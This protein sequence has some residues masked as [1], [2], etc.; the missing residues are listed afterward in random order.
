[1]QINRYCLTSIQSQSFKRLVSECLIYT[2]Q[3][4]ETCENCQSEENKTLH[5]IT[6]RCLLQNQNLNESQEE[7]VSSC[8]GMIKCAHSEIKL[9]WGPPGTGK[10]KTLACLL[11]CLHKL[12]HRSLACAPTNTAIL[13]VAARLH[14]LFQGSAEY[15]TYG[16][17][18]IVLMGNKSRMKLD[19]CPNLKDVF[20]DHRVKNLGECFS[21]LSG[22]QPSVESMI[23]LLVDPE[24]EYSSYKKEK[25]AMS[26]EEFVTLKD[27]GLA[28]AFRSCKQRMKI[29]GTMTFAEY[30]MQNRMDVFERFH[31]EQG[32]ISVLTM[33]QF[34]K[35]TFADLTKKLKFCM[36]TLYTHLPTSFIST[37]QVKN[38]IEV[39]D[40]LD[41]VEARLKVSLNSYQESN[42]GPVCFGSS[43]IK[44]RK[45]LRLIFESVSLPDIP[46][47]GGIEKFCLMNACTI[48][49]TASGSIKLYTEGMNPIKFLVIDEAAQL[50]E[51]ES[52]IPLRLPG[53]NH[54]ILIGDEKQLPA[55]VKSKVIIV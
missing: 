30:V 24:K 28:S 54:C 1:V 39:M 33:K 9:I 51:C 11:F 49:C 12:K 50:K 44:C 46:E 15:E 34:I 20:L 42:I 2:F 31:T 25:G 35:Q 13:Q 36:Q 18:D 53:L 4:G 5:G 14:G 48:L 43:G 55:L 16:L 19:S 29:S 17:G 27:I 10:T 26:L 32:M 8:V 40:L 52:A 37:E 23:N 22:W 3:S 7:A 45:L 47:I 38:M 6:T 21:S 41:S